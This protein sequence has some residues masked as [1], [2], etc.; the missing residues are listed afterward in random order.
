VNDLPLHP[1]IV[2]LPLG[3]AAIA[4]LAAAA[5]GLAVWKSLLTKRSWAIVV[6]LQAIVFLGGI[7]ALKTG[8]QE[9][10]RVEERV[11]EQTIKRHE[12]L[13]ERF[14]WAAGATL[15]VSGAALVLASP[16]ATA[17]LMAATTLAT[18]LTAGLGY[19]VGHAGGAIVYGAGGL[20]SGA[21][22]AGA[23]GADSA[24]RVADDD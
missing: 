17:G 3:L 22:A 6:A 19:Q 15:A 24:A 8:E 12:E 1:A 18:V 2:H 14:V 9:E 5:I 13:G 20:A 7:A 11:A 21:S 23:G 10:E 4:P 16:A